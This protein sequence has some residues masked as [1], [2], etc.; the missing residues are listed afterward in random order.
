M[1][2][3]STKRLDLESW[4][5]SVSDDESLD[6]SY[7]DLVRSLRETTAAVVKHRK[8]SERRNRA[9]LRE[10]SSVVDREI[11]QDMDVYLDERSGVLRVWLP[12]AEDAP[13]LEYRFENLVADFVANFGGSEESRECLTGWRDLFASCAKVLT[14][15]IDDIPEDDSNDADEGNA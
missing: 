1:G 15:A 3:R 10:I 14:D 4:N 7:E 13:A 2:A 9:L 11:R 6:I 8:L 12:L 5:F